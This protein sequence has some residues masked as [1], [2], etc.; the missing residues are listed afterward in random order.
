MISF[1]ALACI[2]ANGQ[3]Y[4]CI[5]ATFPPTEFNKTE[6]MDVQC[7]RIGL[8]VAAQMSDDKPLHRIAWTKCELTKKGDKAA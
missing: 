2:F 1:I 3:P 4:E 8:V 5:T 7:G 6:S